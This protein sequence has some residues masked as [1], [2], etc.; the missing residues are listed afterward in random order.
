MEEKKPSSEPYE[1]NGSNTKNEREV[2]RGPVRLDE[3][4]HDEREK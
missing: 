4:A 1:T 3:N 2:E